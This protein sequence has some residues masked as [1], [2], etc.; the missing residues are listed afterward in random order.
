VTPQRRGDGD[1]SSRA[2]LLPDMEPAGVA[3]PPK[4]QGC[5]RARACAR[6]RVVMCLLCACAPANV[7]MRTYS[8]KTMDTRMPR[9]WETSK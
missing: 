6:N 8:K 9:S 1:A 2:F 7:I 4:G 5:V 3:H